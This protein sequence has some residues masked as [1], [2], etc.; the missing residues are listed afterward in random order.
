MFGG[1]SFFPALIR[2]ALYSGAIAKPPR[3]MLRIVN[4]A[5]SVPPIRVNEAK[6]KISMLILDPPPFSFVMAR[7]GNDRAKKITISKNYN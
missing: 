2:F 6:N 5:R 7:Q 3:S 1:N 4:R